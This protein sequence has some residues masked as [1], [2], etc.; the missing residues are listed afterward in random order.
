MQLI[1]IS[2]QIILREYRPLKRDLNYLS[3]LNKTPHQMTKNSGKTSFNGPLFFWRDKTISWGVTT[4]F[5]K[6]SYFNLINQKSDENKRILII[7]AKINEDNFIV[8][9][10]IKNFFNLAKYAG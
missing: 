4:G 10:P 6:K 2:F 8:I 3:I 5:Y 1:I 7:E 9:W